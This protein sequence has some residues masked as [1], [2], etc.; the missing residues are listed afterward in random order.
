MAGAVCTIGPGGDL[1]HRRLYE[2]RGEAAFWFP[3]IALLS[4]MRLE[5]IAGLRIHDLRQDEETRRWFFDVHP[6]GGRS[7][8]TASSIRTVPVH[9]ELERIGLLLY[10][11]SVAAEQSAKAA[12]AR[13]AHSAS[14]WPALRPQVKGR[15]VSVQWSKWFGRL[16]RKKAGI[17]DRRKVFHS[18]RHSFKRM[19]RDAGIPEEMHDALTGHAGGGG[20]GKSY[21]RGVSLKP[22]IDAMDRIPAPA[23]ISRLE[24][25]LR[26]NPHWPELRA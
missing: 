12:S 19:A 14:L 5:E 22:L 17:T 26:A 15:P 13:S 6:H 10:R 2:W 3:L 1:C 16:L 9:P 11:Q 24:W 21:G 7:V 18:F 8:K 20:V 25:S 23:T 4:G